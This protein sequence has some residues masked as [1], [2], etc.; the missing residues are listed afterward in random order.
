MSQGSASPYHVEQP[1]LKTF[2]PKFG[3]VAFPFYYYCNF[4]IAMNHPCSPLLFLFN[5]VCWNL[6]LAPSS[7]AS[8]STSC[9]YA[10]TM[11]TSIFLLIYKPNIFITNMT[12]TNTLS[13]S[14]PLVISLTKKRRNTH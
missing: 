9:F 7:L 1:C 5:R 3:R 4:F 11:T 2:S 12:V 10:K 6:S 13:S 14:I 8:S